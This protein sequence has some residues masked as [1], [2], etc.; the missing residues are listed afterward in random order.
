[1]S[2][3]NIIEN[4]YLSIDFSG[5]TEV[6]RSDECTE[7]I[8]DLKNGDKYVCTFLTYKNLASKQMGHQISGDYLSGKYYW[9]DRMVFV[10]LLTTN[11]I[12]EV[13]EHMIE[14]GDFELAFRKL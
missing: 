4:L 2:H 14:E 11:R 9:I 8:V 1:M 13:V 5:T 3:A 7:V 10:D 12:R 6:D